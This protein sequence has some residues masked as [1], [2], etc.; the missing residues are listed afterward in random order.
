MS[1]VDQMP[2]K[3]PWR[4]STVRPPLPGESAD[5]LVARV[6][7]GEFANRT[8][9]ITSM[10]G[11]DFTHRAAVS[12][13]D[14]RGISIVADCL[15]V[16]PEDL[17]QRC[18]VVQG[19]PQR[20]RRNA[21]FGTSIDALHVVTTVR[22]FAPASLVI[23][24][25]HRALWML[26]PLPFCEET[27]QFLAQNCPNPH[28]GFTQRW[29]LT[30]GVGLC[31][32]CGEPLTRAQ[33]EVVPHALR[34][35]LGHAVGL[36]HPDPERRSQS[37]GLLPPEISKLPLGNLFDLMCALAGV[38]DPEVRFKSSRRAIDPNAPHPLVAAAMAGAWS[39][40]STWP[41]GF[42][43][44]AG[45]RLAT[46]VGRFGDG[47]S[48]ATLDF[49]LTPSRTKLAP[50]V[51]SVIEQMRERLSGNATDG[52]HVR[53]A[54]ARTGSTASAMAAARRR[55]EV[56]TVF[57]LNGRRVLPLIERTAIDAMTS[58]VRTPHR[59]AAAHLG[60]TFRAV[61]ELILCGLLEAGGQPLSRS[62]METVTQASLKRLTD[63]IRGA[64][65][66]ARK[67]AIPMRH[68]MRS[69]GGRLKPWAAAIQAML[70]GS[71][72]FQMDD[73]EGPLM[74]RVAVPPDYVNLIISLADI[75][76]DA[77][78][79]FAT[80]MSKGDAADALNLM[81]RQYETVLQKWP[82]SNG[83]ERTVPVAAVENMLRIFASASE[84]A[85]RLSIPAA[86]VRRRMREQGVARLSDAGYDRAA[87]DA[88]Y[89]PR[90]GSTSK[91]DD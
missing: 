9:E 50:D 13:Q 3:A 76:D 15:R 90:L 78:R 73:T 28:C 10:A 35:N 37:L 56:P 57:H 70:A 62:T 24:E 11:A 83:W 27:W 42:E 79:P 47:N 84:I 59:Y 38:F 68:A 69:V 77:A 72:K 29:Q 91:T 87:F 44:L 86:A 41:E 43:R 1:V 21:F 30:N 85:H 55:G 67:D 17:A 71:L 49:L 58:M 53:V 48:G 22:R 33:A 26:R 31:D 14:A 34:T 12:R 20:T 60:V 65:G 51:A 74:N 45:D 4:V 88:I 32:S 46:R 63:D 16:D 5:G 25:H 18:A 2:P 54:A 36:V 89:G 80:M 66:P 52:Y 82:S 40:L 81:P 6:A 8:F 7:A 19:G 23:S 61:E 75:A 64:A 39:V